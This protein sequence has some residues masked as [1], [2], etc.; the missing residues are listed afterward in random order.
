MVR[1]KGELSRG[2]IDRGWPYQVALEARH[3]VGHRYYT[4]R[5]FCEG[6]SL[7][8]RGLSF[9]RDGKDFN[10]FCFAEHQHAVTFS[11]RFGGE[12][13][14]PKTRPKWGKAINRPKPLS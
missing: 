13:M 6:M 4:I 8:D 11:E 14:C 1:R 2:R 7:C 9:F 5:Y 12:L 3:C 10:V